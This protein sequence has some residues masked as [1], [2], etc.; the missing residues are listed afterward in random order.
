MTTTTST[1]VCRR[2]HGSGHDPGPTYDGGQSSTLDRLSE[3]GA[4]RK[5][6]TDVKG[7]T[8]TAGRLRLDE[9]YAEIRALIAAGRRKGIQARDMIDALGITSA[10]FYN[11][12][13]PYQA[14][15]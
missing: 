2:C 11:R 6:I 13:G 14:D 7:Y 3:L 9:V 1:R 5:K 12:T 8:T 4:E 15:H 10:A